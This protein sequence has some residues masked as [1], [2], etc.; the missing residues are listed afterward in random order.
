MTEGKRK[1]HRRGTETQRNL[2]I[3]AL[4]TLRT[5]RRLWWM[6][7][8]LLA[9]LDDFRM[10][11]KSFVDV[12]TAAALHSMLSASSSLPALSAWKR[13]SSIKRGIRV[14]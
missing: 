5:T 4:S 14:A 3:S 2:I 7:R 6:P 10:A 13:W 11:A 1:T 9:S 8:F 12:P